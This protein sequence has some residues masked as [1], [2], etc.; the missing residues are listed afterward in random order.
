ML[1]K[2]TC[3]VYVKF[4]NLS[5]LCCWNRV[6]IPDRCS[7]AL[8]VLAIK[9]MFRPRSICGTGKSVITEQCSCVTFVL[10]R[11]SVGGLFGIIVAPLEKPKQR[12][13]QL[14]TANQAHR[15]TCF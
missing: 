11:E 4:V 10:L 12:E 6:Y 5:L 1:L 8:K 15:G 13:A 14:L 3:V 9:K 2:N 7:S